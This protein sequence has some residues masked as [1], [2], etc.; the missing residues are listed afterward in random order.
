M[1]SHQ[2]VQFCACCPVSE[3]EEFV[4]CVCEQCE[5]LL[6]CGNTLQDEE[7]VI[8]QNLPFDNTAVNFDMLESRW[9]LF[10]ALC[11]EEMLFHLRFEFEAI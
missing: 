5:L 1:D 2:S 7:P 8:M 4:P 10:R 9:E 6:Q 3:G 11:T